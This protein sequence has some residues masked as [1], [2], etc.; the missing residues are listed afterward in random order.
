MAK[1]PDIQQSSI[2]SS[3]E[4]LPLLSGSPMPDRGEAFAPKE[5]IAQPRLFG[6]ESFED[7]AREKKLADEL[8]RQKAMK[9]RQVGSLPFNAEENPRS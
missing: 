9:K 8:A 4:E 5:E 1:K 3:G 6:Q 7:L 2:F